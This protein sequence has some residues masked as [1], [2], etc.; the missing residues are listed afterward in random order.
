LDPL[1]AGLPATEQTQLTLVHEFFHCTLTSGSQLSRNQCEAAGPAKDA[2]EFGLPAGAAEFRL[3]LLVK[4]NSKLP[5]ENGG[6]DDDFGKLPAYVIE[7]AETQSLAHGSPQA[8][9]AFTGT[10][11]QPQASIGECIIAVPLQQTIGQPD[12]PRIG[13]DQRQIWIWVTA[14]DEESVAND[15]GPEPA[16][17]RSPFAKFAVHDAGRSM[18]QEEPAQLTWRYMYLKLNAEATRDDVGIAGRH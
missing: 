9:Q 4:I 3:D 10:L 1:F 18:Q 12:D 6:R 13:G 15:L 8:L 11:C 7:R 16:L 2:S 5:S 17:S 14:Q